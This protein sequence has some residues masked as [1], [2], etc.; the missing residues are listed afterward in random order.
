M[1]M[2]GSFYQLPHRC[3]LHLRREWMHLCAVT[4]AVL[5]RSDQESAQSLCHH[6]RERRYEPPTSQPLT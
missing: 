3:R 4:D 5:P 6:F 2:V 1:V